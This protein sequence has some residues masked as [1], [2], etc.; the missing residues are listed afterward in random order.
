MT[1][2][3]L[4]RFMAKVDYASGACWTW[5]AAKGPNGYGYFGANSGSRL[6]HRISYEHFIGEIPDGL[7]IDHLCR[8]RAC[9]NPTHMEPVTP[10]EN[11][12]RGTAG[13]ACRARNV[14]SKGRAKPTRSPLHRERVIAALQRVHESNIGR[15][16]TEAT[17]QR[18]AE[19]RR[20]YWQRKREAA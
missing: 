1:T 4:D 9:V 16:H 10:V 14:R 5:T 15:T 3:Q 18:M 7:Q 6:S 13:E 11:T 8:N 2:E 17:K 19:A 12:R 20:A